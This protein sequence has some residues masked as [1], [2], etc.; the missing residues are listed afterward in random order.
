MKRRGKHWDIVIL[1]TLKHYKIEY[2]IATPS[3]FEHTG[4]NSSLGH[5]IGKAYNYI[6][7]GTYENKKIYK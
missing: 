1:D 7:N 5:Q 6:G 3:L 4:V 2:T